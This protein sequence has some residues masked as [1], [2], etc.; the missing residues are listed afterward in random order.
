MQNKRYS[1]LEANINT[2]S[3]FFVSLLLAYFVL[4]FFGV[5]QSL[6]TS[7]SITLI[8]TVAS[9]TRNYIIRR[10]FNAISNMNRSNEDKKQR[11]G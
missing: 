11:K 6:E 8:F 3:G 9:L 4:P 10:V 5:D 1:F 2:L 7:F